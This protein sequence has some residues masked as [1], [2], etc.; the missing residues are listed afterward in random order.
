VNAS[1]AS[2]SSNRSGP[3]S[4]NFICF[5]VKNCGNR[6]SSFGSGTP[7]NGFR[8]TPPRRNQN[9][10]NALNPDTWLCSVRRP[11]RDCPSITKSRSSRVPSWSNP[12]AHNPAS[13]NHR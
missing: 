3:L 12:R 5:S 4:S 2:F 9:L 7:M 13:F 10:K 8:F 6:F 1:I 11:N